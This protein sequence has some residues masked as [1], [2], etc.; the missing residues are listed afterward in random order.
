MLALIEKF[1]STIKNLGYHSV[2]RIGCSNFDFAE[3]NFTAEFFK[4]VLVFSIFHMLT[5]QL[6]NLYTHIHS[7]GLRASG[8]SHACE[9]MLLVGGRRA[10]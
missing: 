1:S 9:K 4:E 6:H 5:S 2:E 8:K 10:G 7:E 3:L